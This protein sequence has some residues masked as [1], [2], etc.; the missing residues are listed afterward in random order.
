VTIR[1]ISNRAPARIGVLLAA[2]AL[3]V[4]LIVPAGFMPAASASGTPTLVICT[5]Q[6]QMAM[7]MPT[8]MH[9]AGMEHGK[10]PADH[11]GDMASHG[12]FLAAVGGAIDIA[13]PLA[14][15]P[16]PFIVA[17]EPVVHA[18]VARPGLGLAAPPPP[19][20]GPPALA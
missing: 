3:L 14:S 5:G 12:C 20:T 19:K 8:G 9:M 1:R 7:P 17:A 2:L 13:A 6:G 10:A 18:F 11:D 4:R 16:L 15:I